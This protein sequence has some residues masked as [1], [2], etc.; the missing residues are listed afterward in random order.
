VHLLFLQ[1][2]GKEVSSIPHS[3]RVLLSNLTG[4]LS[5]SHIKFKCLFGVSHAYMVTLKLKLYCS[6]GYKL[7]SHLDYVQTKE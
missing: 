4:L 3:I 5:H 7:M 6:A 1:T 2:I